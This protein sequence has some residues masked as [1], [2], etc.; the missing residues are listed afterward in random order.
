MSEFVEFVV[1]GGD[2][3]FDFEG[4]F[5]GGGEGMGGGVS[6]LGDLLSELMMGES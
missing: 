2:F 3:G 6:K 1:E 4:Y 5:D